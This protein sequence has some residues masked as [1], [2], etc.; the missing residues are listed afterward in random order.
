ML[1]DLLVFP[2]VILG[3]IGLKGLLLTVGIV[4][5]IIFLACFFLIVH[6]LLTSLM[7][8]QISTLQDSFVT[9]LEVSMFAAVVSAIVSISTYGVIGLLPM[10]KLPFFFL[11]YFPYSKIWSDLFI[12]ALPTYISH[13]VGRLVAQGLL[14]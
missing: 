5:P 10:L 8:I 7:H 2:I 6:L 4:N 1:S 11:K 14:D 12:V 9:R 13:F 3:A